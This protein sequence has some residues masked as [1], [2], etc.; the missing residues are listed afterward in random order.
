MLI[1]TVVQGDTVFSIARKYAVSPVK[2]IENN[3]LSYP[4]HLIPG[5]KILILTPTRTYIVRGGDTVSKVCRRF[6][7]KKQTLLSNNPALHGRQT[8]HAGTE[9]VIRYDAPLYGVA[10]LN[11]YIYESTSADRFYTMLPYLTYVTFSFFAEPMRP[12]V[13]ECLN[14]GKIPLLR[15]SFCELLE[16]CVLD[17]K[18]FEKRVCEA[19]A[20][21]FRGITLTSPRMLQ[22]NDKAVAFLIDIKKKLLGMDMLLFQEV[23]AE[24]C[25]DYPDAADGIVALYE[26]CHKKDIP[27]F[28]NGER[29]ILESFA[30][31]MEAGKSF[32][33]LSAFGYDE[34]K[35]LTMEQIQK[36][37]IKYKAEINF[38][39][40]KMISF[41]DYT[42]YKNGEKKLLRIHFEALENIKAKLE[43]MHEFGFMGAAVDVGRVP[44][45]Y[46]MMLYV[47]FARVESSH[48]GVFGV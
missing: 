4:D 48:V 45:S 16:G 7:I 38:D 22:N 17:A 2:I 35:A 40:E 6:G 41:L 1:H 11:G 33:E 24:G 13:K 26:K 18:R 20:D 47:M 44:I 3:G 42:L 25:A 28:A 31:Q 30:A 37:A 23:E 39:S 27:C 14:E 36:I 5:Q 10:A 46:V 15:L 8:L 9:L 34:E 12:W 43:L 19:K 32:L 21:G 29:E